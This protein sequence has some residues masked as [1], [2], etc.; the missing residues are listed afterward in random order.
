MLCRGEEEGTECFSLSSQKLDAERERVVA[1]LLGERPR[2][3]GCVVTA[4]IDL[5]RVSGY[6]LGVVIVEAELRAVKQ[7]STT[8]EVE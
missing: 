6:E 1:D 4:R 8:A 5:D 2:L 3:R 7:D